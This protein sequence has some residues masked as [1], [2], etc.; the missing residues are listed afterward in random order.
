MSDP[1]DLRLRRL[2]LALPHLGDGKEHHIA[3][4][5]RAVGCDQA[6]LVADLSALLTRDYEPA[7]FVE[8][9]Q[10]FLT[11]DRVSLI[12]KTFLRPMRLTAIELAALDLGLAMLLAERPPD[13]RPLIRTAREKLRRL[14]ASLPPDLLAADFRHASLEVPGADSVTTLREGVALRRALLIDYQ[15]SGDVVPE[16]RTVLPYGLYYAQG[17]WYLGAYCR[18]SAEVRTFRADRI[19]SAEL[20]NETFEVP[21]TWSPAEVLDG[22]RVLSA[23]AHRELRIR[24]APRVARWIAEREQVPLDRDGSV[25]VTH[26][27]ADMAWAVRHA[28][29]Y[30]AEAEVLA[31]EDVRDEI[32]RRLRTIRE[33]PR[34]DHDTP[35]SSRI[36]SSRCS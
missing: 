15:G 26:P 5:A 11:S 7:G 4:V 35:D 32:A 18:T 36:S 34:L 3:E 19:H 1:A 30:G 13:E 27:M 14:R 10:L 16:R 24:Y 29:Q 12:S 25:T 33:R 20:T 17:M 6:T 2:L 8:G 21:A 28:L 9:V 23:S 31:P 22:E